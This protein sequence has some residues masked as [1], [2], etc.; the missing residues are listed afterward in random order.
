M[1]DQGNVSNVNITSTLPTKAPT[2]TKKHKEE[3]KDLPQK[4]AAEEEHH[5]SLTIFFILLVVGIS[6][7]LVHLLIQTRFHYLPDSI[8]I[9]LIA[10]L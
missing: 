10:S 1:I 8:A 2:T 6:I 9:V 3:A 7:L 4:G 5:S